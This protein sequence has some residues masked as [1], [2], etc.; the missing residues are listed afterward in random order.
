M[1]MHDHHFI[2]P[3]FR[4]DLLLDHTTHRSLDKD[5]RSGVAVRLAGEWCVLTREWEAL[6]AWERS[7]V[8]SAA[9]VLARPKT[10]FTGVTA[11]H[12]YGFPAPQS[13]KWLFVGSL[14]RHHTGPLPD[15]FRARGRAVRSRRAPL[16]FAELCRAPWDAKIYRTGSAFRV[17]S[18]KYALVQAAVHADFHDALT[19]VDAVLGDEGSP[20]LTKDALLEAA[21]E[22]PVRT[23]A[24]RAQK[25]IRLGDPLSESPRES[26][27]RAWLMEA[28]FPAP[29]LQHVFTFPNGRRARVDFWWPQLG[30]ILEYDGWEKMEGSGQRE[31]IRRERRRDEDLLALPEV[32][33]I[34]HVD[35]ARSAEPSQLA[36]SLH[37]HGLWEDPRTRVRIPSSRRSETLQSRSAGR[38]AA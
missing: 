18:L 11:L 34:I 29:V 20:T 30:L 17:V 14:N 13:L 26:R 4:S 35:D 5:L 23:Q 2:P 28:G 24:E 27:T 36:W 25:I 3:V 33:A 19:A 7:E 10:F 31:A 15:T 9:L 16:R 38:R 21:S 8:M 6:A 22:W 37:Q 32:N 12:L 1:G